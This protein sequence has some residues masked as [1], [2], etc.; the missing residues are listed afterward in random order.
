VLL[1]IATSILGLRT[2]SW[3][4]QVI[5]AI[6]DLVWTVQ[7]HGARPAFLNLFR[8]EFDYEY[9][10]Y[11]MLLESL[12]ARYDVPLLDLAAALQ[13]SRGR[14]FC[15]STIRDVTHTN[16]AGARLQAADVT[17]FVAGIVA[18]DR[19]QARGPRPRIVRRSVAL[20]ALVASAP[21]GDHRRAGFS[22]SYVQ[23]PAGEELSITFDKPTNVLG[24]G[25]L[26]H[27][28]AGDVSVI[29][30]GHAPVP[31][32]AYYASSYYE[33]YVFRRLTPTLRVTE[34]TLHQLD[35]MPQVTLNKGQAD[36][37]PRAGR[38]VDLHVF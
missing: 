10:Q 33:H 28:R 22:C 18:D 16:E 3:E 17:R 21:R 24:L 30:P 32:S 8:S 14:A 9:H 12:A 15:L 7:Q 25:M 26:S 2:R 27:P 4:S 31:L 5:D 29:A 23:L 13:R 11:D 34:L 38:L 37:G 1:E 36:P 6:Y 19:E 35:T 20:T